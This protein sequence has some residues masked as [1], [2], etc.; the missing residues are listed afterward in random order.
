LTLESGDVD[1]AISAARSVMV[2]LRD[3]P[4]SDLHGFTLGFLCAALTTRGDLDEALTAARD[5][6]PLLRDA[7]RLFWLFDHLA[8]RAALAGHAKDAA[9]IAGYAEGVHQKLGGAREPMG[10]HAIQRMTKLLRNAMSDEDIAQ[11][12]RLGAQLSED[13]AMTVALG[14]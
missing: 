11:L 3:T 1:S 12:N 2:R 14:V 8:L 7:G 9:L 4:H 6:A 5:A 13:Q 10:R